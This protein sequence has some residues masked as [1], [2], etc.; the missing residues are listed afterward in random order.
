MLPHHA[1]K[2]NVAPGLTWPTALTEQF[3]EPYVYKIIG[4]ITAGHSADRRLRNSED[5]VLLSLLL[6]LLQPLSSLSSGGWGSC[7]CY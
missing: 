4:M 1:N 7:A 5:S 3:T 2:N 6:P